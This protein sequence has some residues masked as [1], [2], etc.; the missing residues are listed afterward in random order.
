MPLEAVQSLRKAWAALRCA[1]RWVMEKPALP[2]SW[3][4]ITRTCLGEGAGEGRW[5]P[6]G[7]GDGVGAHLCK[8]GTLS[9]VRRLPRVDTT[10][11]LSEQSHCTCR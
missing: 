6:R 11:K 10:L 3:D 7:Q 1:R 4:R 9:W 2:S 8:G 5:G